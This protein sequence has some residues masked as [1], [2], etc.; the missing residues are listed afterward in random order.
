M[1][2]MSGAGLCRVVR[3]RWPDMSVL[4]FSGYADVDEISGDMPR[5]TKPFRQV[6]LMAN[7]IRFAFRAAERATFGLRRSADAGGAPGP[8]R[9]DTP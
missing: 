9:T 2:G 6:D 4:I 8:T 7:S 3:G 1:P 5:L